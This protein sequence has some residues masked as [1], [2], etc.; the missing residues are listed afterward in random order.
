MLGTF[1]NFDAQQTCVQRGGQISMMLAHTAAFCVCQ[2]VIP[3]T[4]RISC[5]DGAIESQYSGSLTPTRVACWGPSGQCRYISIRI[6]RTTV[7]LDRC[8]YFDP[9][10]SIH[11]KLRT[12]DQNG[13]LRLSC[14]SSDA[15]HDVDKQCEQVERDYFFRS[16]D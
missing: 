8:L 7:K 11:C 13:P 10:M 3:T 1:P 2:S 9:T 6:F 4:S 12:H 5:D 15:G 14:R 16:H